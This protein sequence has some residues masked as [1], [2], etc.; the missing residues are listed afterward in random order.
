[1][2]HRLLLAVICL[3]P[4]FSTSIAADDSASAQLN[5]VDA[6]IRLS[7]EIAAL[8]QVID[9]EQ[10]TLDELL[11]V[12]ERVSKA[13]SL[14]SLG[15][16]VD[17][18]EF[19]LQE[20]QDRHARVWMAELLARKYD[21][22]VDW[23]KHSANDMKSM[24]ERI[25]YAQMLRQQYGNR[26]DWREH[27]MAEMKEMRRKMIVATNLARSGEIVD[28]RMVTVPPDPLKGVEPEKAAFIQSLADN[29]RTTPKRILAL[30][31]TSQEI[32]KDNGID[33]DTGSLVSAAH[34]IDTKAPTLGI[35][36]CLAEYV[37]YRRSGMSHIDAV[38]QVINDHATR[39]LSYDVG[40]FRWRFTFSKVISESDGLGLYTVVGT[41]ENVGKTEFKVPE[42]G[43]MLTLVDQQSREYTPVLESRGDMVLR[44]SIPVQFRYS[45]KVP[46]DAKVSSFKIRELDDEINQFDS[47]RFQTIEVQEKRDPRQLSF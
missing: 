42:H 36:N 4:S 45:F 27:D 35:P 41:I 9:W 23:R 22:H 31:Q 6:R 7:D 30:V 20:L 46:A 29:A 19:S 47:D 44:P 3:A 33:A 21:H 24:H 26:V 34:E 2:F 25:N 32:L 12:K 13:N 38:K 43:T 5:D 14:A 15:D 18:Q 40:S 11:N 17:W 16:K 37:E 28:W 39:D 1:V 8:G 10:N